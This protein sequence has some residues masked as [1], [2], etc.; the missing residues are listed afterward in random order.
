MEQALHQVPFGDQPMVGACRAPPRPCIA[1]RCTTGLATLA[2]PCSALPAQDV[3]FHPTQS[4]LATGLIDGHLLVHSYSAEAAA[5]RS[6]MKAHSDTCRAVRFTLA[7]DLLISGS[8]DQSLLAVDVETGKATARKK[9]AHDNAINRLAAV[10]ATLTASGAAARGGG[11]PF[12]CVHVLFLPQ[13]RPTMQTSQ[14]WRD[15]LAGARA[16]CGV[17]CA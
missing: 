10:G 17:R 15:R 8:A 13:R 7:G 5:E 16:T 4:L 12:N 6:S 9:E 1:L 14:A 3:D 2:R 11:G